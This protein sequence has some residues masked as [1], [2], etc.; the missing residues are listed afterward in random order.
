MDTLALHIELQPP[1]PWSEILISWLSEEG[2]NAF[3]ETKKGIV[4]Y[5]SMDDV[6]KEDLSAKIIGWGKEREVELSLTQEIIPHKNWNAEWES[7]FQPVIVEKYLSILAPFHNKK[8]SIGMVVEIQPQMSFGTGHHQTTW[9]MSKAL[10]ELDS[11]PER[12]LDMGTGTGILAIVAEKLGAKEILA[13]DIEEWSAEN[14]R[15]NAQRNSCSKIKTLHGDIDLVKNKK[16]GLILAN[17]NKNVLKSHFEAYS[18][19]LENDG[20]ILISGFFET[21]ISD[22]A[23]FVD[24]LNFVIEKKWSKETWAALQ[25]KRKET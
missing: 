21:D 16:F 14:A 22:M 7:D 5:A 9:M 19:A 20:R 18:E 24:Q 6:R 25:L 10:F 8:D 2:C 1:T 4:A 13:I 11:L 12:V 23:N 3:E 15:E 17:I